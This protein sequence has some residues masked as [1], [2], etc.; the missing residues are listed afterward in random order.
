MDNQ[1]QSLVNNFIGKA[2]KDCLYTNIGDNSQP[3]VLFML[4]AQNFSS[5]LKW[6]TNPNLPSGKL[7]Q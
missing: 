2:L 1:H 3:H 5:I 6:L 4:E 7:P